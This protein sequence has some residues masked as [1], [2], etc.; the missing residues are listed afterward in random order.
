MAITGRK[1]RPAPV[2]LLIYIAQAVRQ[3]PFPLATCVAA[4]ILS[5]PARSC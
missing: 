5:F 3:S 4:R 2:H 1:G